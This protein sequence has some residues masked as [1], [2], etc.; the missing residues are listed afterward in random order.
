MPDES[1]PSFLESLCF[2]HAVAKWCERF[3]GRSS[4]WNFQRHS[5]PY[6]ELIFFIDG[7]ARIDAGDES[8]D[9]SL[10]DVV[11]YPPGLPHQEHLDMGSRQEII[12]IWADLGPCPSFDHA[13]KL[14]DLRGTMRE[15]FEI[16]YLEFT[17]NRAMA[18]DVIASCLKTL[19]LLIRQS[20]CETPRENDSQVERCLS[21]IHEHFTGNFGIETLAQTISVSPSYLFRI[22]KRRMRVT[23][24]HYRNLVRIDKAR[25]L[26]L[27]RRFT[28]EEIAEH[29][30]FEDGR[31]FSRTFKK[32]TGLSPSE[33]RKKQLAG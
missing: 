22:F 16:I 11:V 31:Y 1:I 20:Y 25:L 4:I 21:Y 14:K 2:D 26:L 30:G 28:V 18:G 33:F 32:E 15:L 5:H 17:G 12:C 13:I 27:D 8:V 24:M 7:K 3:D 19:F 6:F 23:P 10:F 29:V 9:I